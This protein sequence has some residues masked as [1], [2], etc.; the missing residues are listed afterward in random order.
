MAFYVDIAGRLANKDKFISYTYRILDHF[1]GERI[2]R[3]VDININVFQTSGKNVVGECY[4]DKESITIDLYKKD[5]RRK[6]N[7]E[8]IAQNLAHELV[9]AKQFIRGEI[10]EEHMKFR[11]KSGYVKDCSNMA[12]RDQPWEREAFKLEQELFEL[13]WQ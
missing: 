1:F 12:Y 4:G 10:S 3:D 11:Y 6:L 5:G 13:Y 7:T 9:H 8:A 2:K